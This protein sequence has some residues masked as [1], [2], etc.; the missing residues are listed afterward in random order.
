[1]NFIK[2]FGKEMYKGF[3]EGIPNNDI[4]EIITVHFDFFSLKYR[5]YTT[6]KNGFRM[7]L[8]QFYRKL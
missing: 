7:A 2:D 8:T 4:N 5:K 1:M 6:S 3:Y